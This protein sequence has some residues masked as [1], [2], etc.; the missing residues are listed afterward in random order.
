MIY[1]IIIMYIKNVQAI[2]NDHI[3][4]RQFELC[5]WASKNYTKSKFMADTNVVIINTSEP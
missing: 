2:R 4:T 1:C 5:E 3:N